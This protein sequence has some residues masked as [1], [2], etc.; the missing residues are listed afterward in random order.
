[1]E[2][3]CDNPSCKNY[4]PV[5]DRTALDGFFNKLLEYLEYHEEDIAVGIN[6]LGDLKGVFRFCFGREA[7]C[8][9]EK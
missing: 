2:T 9:E 3:I 4:T 5:K 8:E 7:V 6:D 1:M